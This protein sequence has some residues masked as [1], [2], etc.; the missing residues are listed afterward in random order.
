MYLQIT[1]TYIY[2]GYPKLKSGFGFGLT[3][4][5]TTHALSHLTAGATLQ[6]DVIANFQFQ[7]LGSY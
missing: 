6:D 7:R 3:G 4:H 5:K 2:N 1:I